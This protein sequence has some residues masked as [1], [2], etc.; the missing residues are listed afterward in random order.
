MVQADA[1]AGAGVRP[2]NP[3]RDLP[4]VTSL[5]GRVF[6]AELKL[7]SVLSPEALRWMRRC[8]SV[9][10]LWFGLDA[11][12]DSNLAGF[13]WHEGGRIVGN[14]NIAP[15]SSAGRQWVLSNVAV[16]PTCRGHGIA[17]A[18]VDACI[19]Y[20]ADRGGERV[21]L[22][23]WESNVAARRLYE[24]R[25]F[26]PVST[27]HRLEFALGQVRALAERPEGGQAL[28]WRRPHGGDS[29]ALA[30]IAAKLSPFDTQ[31]L[32]PSAA[33]AFEGA[34]WG[35]LGDFGAVLG[36]GRRQVRLVL[37]Q[38]DSV[39]GGVAVRTSRQ[40]WSRLTIL[41]APTDLEECADPVAAKSAEL[42]S[43]QAGRRVLCDLPESLVLLS[44]RLGQRGFQHTDSLLQMA[45]VLS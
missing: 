33:S 14:A 30:S 39:R 21:L 5:L 29:Y 15:L 9:A 42:A 37:C 44:D 10:W 1:T 35:W 45:L 26:R 28:R 12:F 41:L 4:A 36:L 20:V 17:G 22:H 23:V 38:G 24:R 34:S 3:F 2:F 8:P 25:S 18:L 13:V 19:R 16:E 6:G 7:D 31:V 40:P 43:L 11:W 32:R 27:T